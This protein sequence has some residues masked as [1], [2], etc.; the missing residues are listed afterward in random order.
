MFDENKYM[1]LA[2]IDLGTNTFNLLVADVSVDRFDILHADK[3]GVL[4][5]MGGINEKKISAE[6]Q[7]RA[8]HCLQ[9][10]KS[11]CD[12]LACQTIIAVGTSAVRDASNQQEFIDAV[13]ESC[14]IEIRVISGLEE[15]KWIYEGVR[16]SY[17]FAQKSIVMDIGGGSTEFIVAD[18]SGVLDEKSLNI[19]VSRVFQ[20]NIL[21][22]PATVEEVQQV[23][24][25]FEANSEGFFENKH[26][27]ILVGSSGSFESYYELMYER[28]FPECI[29]QVELPLDPF[30]EILNEIIYSNLQERMDNPHIIA[31]RKRM[32]VLAAI[33]TQWIM[34]RLQVNRVIVSPCSLKEGLLRS[35][36]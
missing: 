19:G 31:I 5:G 33:K 15:A 1:R 18:Q 36:H 6:A 23:K 17:D 7:G 26:I 22:D 4:L 21:S 28:E 29:E 32:I 20:Q 27:P 2:V 30:T 24:N 3:Q 9:K 12:R 25:W 13:R 35:F 10:Y 8:I 14:G 34:E 11:E 16:W